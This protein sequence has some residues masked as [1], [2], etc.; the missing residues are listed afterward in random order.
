MNENTWKLHGKPRIKFV[1]TCFRSALSDRRMHDAWRN[2]DTLVDYINERYRLSD[3]TRVDKAALLRGF[4]KELQD[5][6]AAGNKLIGDGGVEVRV[7]RHNFATKKVRH[8]FFYA[9]STGVV[10][11]FPTAANSTA[12]VANS[13]SNVLPPITRQQVLHLDEPAKK[14]F[15]AAPVQMQQEENTYQHTQQDNA[16]WAPTITYWDSGDARRIFAPK[17]VHGSTC[18]VLQV[19][20]D[21]IARLDSVNE[22]HDK[23]RDV[24]DGGDEN[25]TCTAA[26][27]FAIRQRSMY[28][29][30]ALKTFVKQVRNLERWTWQKCIED[31]IEKMND[32]G[33]EAFSDWKQLSR[34]HRKLVVS[35]ECTFG[36][37]PEQKD[38]MPLFFTENPD[39]MEAF[40][41]YGVQQ[42]K[43][44]SVEVMHSYVH[45]TLIP[46]LI[47]N[48]AQGTVLNDE[49]EGDLEKPAEIAPEM[50]SAFLKRY[51]LTKLTIQ[52]VARWMHVVGFCY[53]N[54][55]KHHFVDGHEKPATLA[56]RPVFTQ[57]Y[58]DYE[59]RAHRWIQITLIEATALENEGKLAKH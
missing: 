48:A 50:K 29:S 53:K 20:F 57:K 27:I 56:Y 49:N 45:E 39:A 38:R 2:I 21:R 47:D 31:A 36:K 40:K 51:G 24:I 44:L 23:W 12:W 15:K 4:N 17:N 13:T 25:N 32:I 16:S 54:R 41:R 52:T 18:L 14:K 19:V 9:T 8:Y 33:I 28:L 11:Q 46:R 42:L 22:A 58:F 35:K 55:Q 26:D 7:Y 1:A 10:P 6:T 59:L 37:A 5:T 34:W 43:S 30:V 3:E